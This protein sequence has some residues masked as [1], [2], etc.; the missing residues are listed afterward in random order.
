M[1][2]IINIVGFKYNQ[3]WRMSS[4]LHE[5]DAICIRSSDAAIKHIFLMVVRR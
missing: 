3:S 5:H 4:Q 1:V 2:I